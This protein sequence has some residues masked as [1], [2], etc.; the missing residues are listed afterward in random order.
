MPRTKSKPKSTGED[1]VV[2]IDG[3]DGNDDKVLD[4]TPWDD[5]LKRDQVFKDIFLMVSCNKFND[6]RIDELRSIIIN[7]AQHSQSSIDAIFSGEQRAQVQ[8]T[9]DQ[10]DVYATKLKSAQTK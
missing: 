6:T 2:V 3:N 5:I 7:F 1:E 9:I 10:I 8:K 4:V